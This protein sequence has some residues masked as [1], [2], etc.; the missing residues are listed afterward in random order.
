MVY[1]RKAHTPPTTT[2]TEPKRVI[3]GPKSRIERPCGVV[4]NLRTQEII[5]AGVRFNS[6]P[7][8]YS[9]EIV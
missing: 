6:V 5:V 1:D 2:M 7:A 9:P 4:L 8:Y 3:G